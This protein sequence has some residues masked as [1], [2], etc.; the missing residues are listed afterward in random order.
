M[1]E[2]TEGMEWEVSVNHFER[3]SKP[4]CVAVVESLLLLN[5]AI[6]KM[7]RDAT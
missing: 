1:K 6:E 7:T 2:N 4:V 5:D 3:Q